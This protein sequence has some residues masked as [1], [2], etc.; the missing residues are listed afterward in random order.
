MK[1]PSKRYVIAVRRSR[2][3]ERRPSDN[4][5]IGGKAAPYRHRAR[6]ENVQNPCRT[7]INGDC[8]VRARWRRGRRA[9]VALIDGTAGGVMEC[10][11]RWL[12]WV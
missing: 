2:V 10:S 4:F 8:D 9:K 11:R 12:A 7:K 6:T 5:G 3:R 1:P